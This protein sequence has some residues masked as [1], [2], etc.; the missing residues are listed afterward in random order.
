MSQ[1]LPL[2]SFASHQ[3]F[4]PKPFL[5]SLYFVSYKINMSSTQTL[6]QTH[7][8]LILNSTSSPPEVKTIPT[9]QPGPGSVVAHIEAVNILSYASD[10]YNGTRQYPFPTPLVIGFSAIARV[11]SPGPDATKT[12]ARAAG[13]VRYVRERQG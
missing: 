3:V 8:A 2:F 13:S 9:P 10:I 6:P 12:Q 11:V 4:T 5:S 7:R 1:A